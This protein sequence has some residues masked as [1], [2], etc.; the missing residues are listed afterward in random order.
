M[1]IKY[2]KAVS[3][4][5]SNSNDIRRE[6]ASFQDAVKKLSDGINKSGTD[7][8]DSKFKELSGHIRGVANSSKQTIQ[9]GER[10]CVAIDKFAQIASEVY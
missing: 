3:D 10:T 7:W 9:S 4:T 2:G 5:D 1:C 6:I 8:N